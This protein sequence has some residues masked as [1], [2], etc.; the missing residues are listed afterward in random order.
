MFN[1]DYYQ[2]TKKLLTNSEFVNNFSYAKH[3]NNNFKKCI[4]VYHQ[5]V[6]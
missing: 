6:L 4:K 2:V 3:T 1:H 5:D